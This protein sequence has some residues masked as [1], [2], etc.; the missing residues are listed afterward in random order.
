M[1]TRL[2][3][4]LEVETQRPRFFQAAVSSVVEVEDA[5]SVER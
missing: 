1:N 2:Q 5:S 4:R 3:E